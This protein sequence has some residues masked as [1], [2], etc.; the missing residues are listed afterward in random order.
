MAE[1]VFTRAGDTALYWADPADRVAA[2]LA[3][4]PGELGDR[5]TLTRTWADG[6]GAYVFLGVPAP[7]ST[8]FL[9]ALRTWLGHYA[10]EGPPRF[11]WLADPTAPPIR[12]ETT[13]LTV[14]ADRD[15]DWVAD[16]ASFQLADYRLAL[17]GGGAVAP[18]E[19]AAG[20]G[21]AVA[22]AADRSAVTL[23]SPTARFPARRTTTLLGMAAGQSGAWRFVIDAPDG[24][25]DA[26]TG[27]GAGLRFFTPGE[28]GVVRTVRF[29][30]VRQPDGADLEFHA[31]IDPL[32]PLDGGRTSLGFFAG[33]TGEGDPPALPSGYAT[34]LGHGVALRPLA[35][36][37]GAAGPARL[38]F[39]LAPYLSD[40][41]GNAG[42]HLVPDGPFAVESPVESPV[43]TSVGAG[44]AGPRVICGVSGLEYLGLPAEG[45][46]LA[47]RPGQ[48]AYAPLGPARTGA[49]SL[50]SHG[51]TSWVSVAADA[52]TVTYYSQPEDAPL[53]TAGSP[54]A[55]GGVDLLEFCEV[56][57][58]APAGTAFPM[59]PFHGL[60]DGAIDRAVAVER[61]AVAPT[62]RA[63][64]LP[65]EGGAPA[66]GADST[67]A[68]TPQGLAVGLAPDLGWN[69]LGIGHD[70]DAAAEPDLRFTAVTGP[71]RQAMQTNN[72]FLV[73]GDPQEFNRFGSV[74]YELTTA[75]LDVIATIPEEHGGVPAEVLRAV[76]G[77]MHDTG[78]DTR[79]AFLAALVEAVPGIT[80]AEQ[81]VFLR[82]G[83]RLT[84]VAGGWPFRLSPDSWR[85]S[86]HL[87][88]KF[89]PGRSIV[90]LV[91]DVSTWAWPAAASRT[92]RPADAQA[93]IR[94]VIDAARSAPAGSPYASF[95]QVVRDP[96]WTGVLALSAEVPLEQLPAEL[97]VL[98]AGID[99]E[100]FT[101][102]HLGI[103]LTPFRRVGG[104]LTFERSAM[105]GLIDYQNP[106][107]Q[108]FSENIHFAFRVLQLTVGVRNSVVTAFS[109][110]VELLVNRLFGAPA[111]LLPTTR[112]NN[113]VLDGAL[114]RQQLPDGTAHDTFV[115]AMA[116]Q[117]TFRLDGPVLRSVELLSTQLVT[118][119]AADPA[120][121]RANVDA[122]FQLAGNLRFH[123]PERFDPFCYGPDAAGADGYLRFGGLAVAMSFDLGDPA[124]TT[125]FTL[126]DGNLSLDAANSRARA[127]SLAARFPIRPNGLIATPDPALATGAPPPPQTPTD[128]GYVSV[129]APLEQA[130]LAQPWYGL[131]YTVDLGSLGALAGS[132]ALAL[133]VLVAWSPATGDTGPG[134]Y[135]GVRL[136][137]ANGSVG[138]GLPLQGVVTM[139]FRSVEFLVGE[140]PELPRTYTLRL[141]DFALRLLGLAL[142]P[143][144]ND[145]I[146]FGNPDQGGASKVG[147]YLAY[148][149][150][151]D[152]KR[153]PPPPV[154]AALR[155]AGRG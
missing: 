96:D 110:R 42:Y 67:V 144:H 115:F 54:A 95:L 64:L 59:A 80:E 78:Y 9:A 137:G 16:G 29:A 125:R 26:F 123:E 113:I 135:L 126:R 117:N 116:G 48:P 109:S 13:V 6:L 119:R 124:G 82:Y 76:R 146:L 141:R 130:V 55:A 84:P 45:G 91:E 17:A 108:Y 34:V 60:V 94:G 31:Q 61:L 86:T 153:L 106:E 89:V 118:E 53:Y 22:D 20:W 105:F 41:A 103:P 43:G 139:G 62:R 57:A 35:A 8:G 39:G 143:G 140:E 120:S 73:L 151:A 90:D 56:P 70:G 134:I 111:R 129:T 114:Q 87:I 148:A 142:P 28:A 2:F 83:G 99:P 36:G 5:P 47:F 18:A 136:P 93:A 100:R 46:A 15:G 149:S 154:R 3:S 79:T 112:G 81:R 127:Q 21:F 128:L 44:G 4:D 50:T 147:W 33:T 92:G 121:G 122:V 102:H 25:G 52:D 85:E 12:W 71:F 75:A 152:P 98:A 40:E 27:L 68:V 107:D 66:E 77:A 23:Y 51:T 49:D 150:A 58:A 97:Q 88:V 1:P 74:A 37:A 145:V 65:G 24:G 11:L 104:R 32:R 155:S 133:Q 131:D 72:L 38:V 101:A 132:K 10:P 14:R 30:V 138:A 19:T 7:D 63:V 69:W